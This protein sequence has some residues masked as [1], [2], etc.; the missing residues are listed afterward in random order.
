MLLSCA[1]ALIIKDAELRCNAVWRCSWV[2]QVEI[3]QD[4]QAMVP[5]HSTELA[6]ALELE[7]AKSASNARVV[8][9]GPAL[10]SFLS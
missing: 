1:G 5:G 10:P 7:H 9:I 6:R 8:E 4:L 3:L 2:V